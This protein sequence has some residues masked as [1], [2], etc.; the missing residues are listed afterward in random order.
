MKTADETQKPTCGPLYLE[1][2]TQYTDG[3]PEKVR[4][5]A[6]GFIHGQ[7]EKVYLG[8]CQ[9][10]M[11]RPSPERLEM[12]DTLA[13]D[14]ANRYGLL[15][16]YLPSVGEFWLCRDEAAFISV[17]EHMLR[18]KPNSPGWHHWRAWLCGIPNGEIDPRFHERKGYGESCDVVSDPKPLLRGEQAAR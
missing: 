8:A 9:A 3:D 4:L 16:T 5:F 18:M 12:V 2:L 13:M 14:A 1:A 15:M 10:A 17:S 6:A 7:A 11:F